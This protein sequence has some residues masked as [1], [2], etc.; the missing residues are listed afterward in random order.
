[1]LDSTKIFNST[2]TS[3]SILHIVLIFIICFFVIIG[4]T[5]YFELYRRQKFGNQHITHHSNVEFQSESE[6]NSQE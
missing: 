5:F 4:F 3:P 1:M 2:N 6:I